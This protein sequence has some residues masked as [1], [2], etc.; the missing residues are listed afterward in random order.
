MT[1]G[2]STAAP[3]PE[4]IAAVATPPGQGGIGI[5]RISGPMAAAIGAS[6]T[7]AKLIARRPALRRFDRNGEHLDKGIVLYFPAPGS[8]TG[9]DVVELQGHG[10][11]MVLQMVLEAVL[12]EGA[13][14]ARPGEFTERA[15][16]NGKLDLAQAE[17]VADLIGS[18]SAAAA[19]GALRSLAGTFST[20]VNELDAD[21]TRLRVYVEASIDFPDEEVEFLESGQVGER[22][23]SLAVSMQGLLEQ[24]RQGVLISQGVNV[25]LV[26]PPNAGKSSLL[27]RLTGEETAIVT[28][29]PGTTRDLLK[30]DLVLDNLPLRLVD[31]AGL[32]NTDDPVEV[33]GVRRARNEAERA[34]LVLVLHDMAER[35]GQDPVAEWPRA[36]LVD[37]KIDLVGAEPGIDRS[38]RPQRVRI[39]CLT[40]AG[41]GSL[42]EAIKERVG[43]TGGE[44]AFSARRRH[45]LALRQAVGALRAASRRLQEGSPG[46]IIAEEL[47]QA[48]LALGEITGATAPDDLLGEI[49]STFCIGK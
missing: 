39:S 31:T 36:L 35:V 43:F 2:Q 7:G 17:A 13:R 42:K 41:I 40:G 10:G 21:I 12:G 32:R 26:G 11:P 5:V 20:A 27:N 38:Q 9:E 29:I 14:L 4:T 15:Y 48:H 22:I 34:D 30:V 44:S 23:V 45:L 47:R 25:A 16:V 37:N 49:F 24:G 18:A 1:S 28:N 19:R 46:E 8:F 3:G 6:I 33:E